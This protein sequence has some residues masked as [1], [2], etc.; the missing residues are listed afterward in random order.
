MKRVLK[1]VLAAV[2]AL[3]LAAAS[4]AAGRLARGAESAAADRA[5]VMSQTRGSRPRRRRTRDALTPGGWGGERIRFEVT[6]GGARGEDGCAHG[7][8]E[9]RIVVDAAGRFDAEGVHYEERA[10]PERAGESAPRYPV[11]LSGRVGGSLMKLTVTRRDNGEEVGT[12]TLVRGGEAKL[13]KCQ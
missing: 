6:A 7:R 10:G 5:G 3:Q 11:R 4:P 8:V 13:V 1:G 2:A 9:G 12:Y